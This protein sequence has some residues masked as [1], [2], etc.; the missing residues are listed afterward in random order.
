MGEWLEHFL[1]VVARQAEAAVGRAERIKD[2]LS[3]RTI[4]TS[5]LLVLLGTCRVIARARQAAAHGAV[6]TV[7]TTEICAEVSEPVLRRSH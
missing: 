2:V 3:H 6:Q 5:F 1:N 4:P 7:A